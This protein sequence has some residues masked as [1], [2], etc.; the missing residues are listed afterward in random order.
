[1]SGKLKSVHGNDIEIISLTPDN[2]ADYGVCGYKDAKKHLE[3]QR[4]VE[5]YREFYPKGLRIKALISKTGGY[6]GMIEYVPGKYAHRPVNA[7]GYLFIHCIFVGFK[8]EFKGKGYATLLIQECINEAKAQKMS[9]VAVVTRK[10]SFMAKRDIF[11]KNGFESVD[12]VKPDFELLALKF[13]KDA[14][15]PSFKEISTE[16]YQNGLTILRSAQCPYSVKNVDSIMETARKMKIPVNLVE[17][18]DAGSV[19]QT[20]C[21]FGTFCIIKDGKVLSHHPISNTRFENIMKS[22]K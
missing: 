17:L 15:T 21:A 13:S 19:Q 20:P 1:M 16:K 3:L 11:I 2:L 6:Q 9:G 5:W 7:E 22:V 12:D 8:N 10:G 4:K 18:K 14:K